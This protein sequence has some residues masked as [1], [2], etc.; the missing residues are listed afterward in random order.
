MCARVTPAAAALDFVDI[1]RVHT[2]DIPP[3]LQADVHATAWAAQVRPDTS[4]SPV[5]WE[6]FNTQVQATCCWGRQNWA[7]GKKKL[8]DYDRLSGRGKAWY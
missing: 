4:P 5:L 6:F 2:K 7:T 8:P 1:E 3:S